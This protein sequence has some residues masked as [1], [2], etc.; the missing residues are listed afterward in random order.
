VFFT[1]IIV[2]ITT[3]TIIYS[4]QDVHT[5][6]TSSSIRKEHLKPLKSPSTINNSS[7]CSVH[8]IDKLIIA[9]PDLAGERSGS[10][11]SWA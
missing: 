9:Q 5:K 7:S 6:F 1:I 2:I 10:S 3:T 8:Y 11:L 4:H